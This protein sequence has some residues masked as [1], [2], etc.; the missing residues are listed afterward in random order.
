MGKHMPYCIPHRRELSDEER[1]LLRFLLERE[2]PA[3]LPEMSQLKVV[4][5]C[6]CGACPT[7]LLGSTL[8]AAPATGSPFEQVASYRGKNKEGV[9]VAVALIA[10]NG[11]L[12][13]LEAWAPYGDDIRS[14]PSIDDLERFVW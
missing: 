6:G 14:W 13:E 11:A 12:A 8:E 10:R 1:L 7:I 5:R 3:R 4:A 9:E 2:A